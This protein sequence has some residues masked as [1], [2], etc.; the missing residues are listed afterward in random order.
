MKRHRAADWPLEV[1]LVALAVI[2]CMAS[3]SL[4]LAG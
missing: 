2:G 3:V 4:R 1:I